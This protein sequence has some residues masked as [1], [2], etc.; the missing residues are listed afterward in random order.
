M[1]QHRRLFRGR[2]GP[3]DRRLPEHNARRRRR[4]QDQED[5]QEKYPVTPKEEH[6]NDSIEQDMQSEEEAGVPASSH[7][8]GN[9]SNTIEEEAS[10]TPLPEH[11]AI[12]HLQQ[13]IR[14]VRSSIQ[15]S[16]TLSDP[17]K[18]QKHVLQAVANCLKEWKC[19]LAQYSLDPAQ[20][21]ETALVIFEL[22]QQAL[23]C[24]PLAGSKPGYFKRCGAIVAEMVLHFLETN[25]PDPDVLFTEKQ[26][27]AVAK[28]K[29]NA[30]KAVD[31]G[32]SP[33]KSVQKNLD[34]ATKTKK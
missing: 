4:T 5:R 12:Q 24:G 13:R 30:R 3:T 19:I 9:E 28:W 14:N 1:Q 22:L 18:Y 11:A 21:K 33:S 23:Q 32:S 27:R 7:D 25:L 20:Q 31:K 8:T 6:A 17:S 29:D 16:Q 34:K 2:G 10:V 26:Y 15:T